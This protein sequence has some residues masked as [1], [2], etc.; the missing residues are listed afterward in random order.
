M[1]QM[2]RVAI[3]LLLVLLPSAAWAQAEKR[4]ALLIG[5]QGYPR[6]VGP[7][8]NPHK[9]VRIVAAALTKIG[10]ET[11]DPV[12]DA[13][14]EQTLYAVHDFAD[15][16][17]AAGPGALGFLYYSGHGAAVGGDNFLV[18]VNAKGT[19]RRDLDVSG[20]KLAEIIVIL[21]E[22]A[23]QA[24]HFIVFDACRNNLS[25]MRGSKGFLTVAEKPGMLVA[26]ST[27]PGATASDEGKDSGPY[28]AALAAA[29]VVPGRN[30]GDT[31]FDVR[32]RVAA[33]TAQEQI[34]WTQDGLL[35]RVHF[36]G[37]VTKSL[38]PPLAPSVLSE[39]GQAWGMIKATT[40]QPILE[41]FVRQFGDTVYA[42]MA[43]ER[44]AE[45]KKQQVAVTAPLPSA[46][47]VVPKPALS[48]G[49]APVPIGPDAGNYSGSSAV[50]DGR[51]SGM[52]IAYAAAPGNI[53]MDG[54]ERGS[55]FTKALL[56]NIGVGDRPISEV[57]GHV[58][59]DVFRETDNRQSPWYVSLLTAPFYLAP[60]RLQWGGWAVIEQSEQA[61]VGS[62]LKDKRIALVI[63]NANYSSIQML[64]G[65][66]N[67]AV[68]VERKLKTLGFRVLL[69]INARK[70]D[71]D[72]AIRQFQRQLAGADVG[73]FYYSGHG[74]QTSRADQHHPVNHL[75]PVDFRVPSGGMVDGTVPL[76]DVLKTLE[77]HARV[78]LVFL[79]ACRSDPQLDEAA[80]RIGKQ[81]R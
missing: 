2:V 65:P 51:P 5:N 41:A 1:L 58:G 61:K 72:G 32:S 45:L 4:I 35:H 80:R 7:L 74:F 39:A 36:G 24:V 64:Q 10:F 79:D 50:N 9:D 18:P 37:E 78:S 30:H 40:K 31:F 15:R 68:E 73:L 38:E 54:D 43:R 66:A 22:S 16:L 69:L 19:T 11:I 21:N 63:G 14:R 48:P 49:F 60:P 13:S 62:E 28:A 59:R 52:L 53:S 25:G 34:P 81:T 27:A 56:K 55:P 71:I 8:K 44:L 67:D 3:V 42:A 47:P 77:K 20:V 33:L 57:M 23:P 70:S 29:L 75:V 12:R 76:D 6:E 17:R 26:F 46:K